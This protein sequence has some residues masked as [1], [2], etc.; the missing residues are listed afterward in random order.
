VS[1]TPTLDLRPASP[2]PTITLRPYQEEAVAAVLAKED[3]G[4]KRQVVA[5]PTGCGKTTVFT[6]LA[7]RLDRETILLVHRDELVRQAVERFQLVWPDASVG[8][9]KAERN[10]VG[11]QVV[12]ASIQTLARERRRKMLVP[13][14]EFVIV[15]ECHHAP[16]NTY[17]AVLEHLRC[18]EDDGPLLLGV[19]ATPDR[20][21][22]R[23]LIEI[24]Q[25][26]THRYSLRTAMMEGYLCDLKAV[27]VL[28]Q[29]DLDNVKTSRGDYQ[30]GALSDAMIEADAP[31]HIV[32]AWHEHASDRKTLVFVPTVA[33][34]EA[35]SNQFQATGANADWVCGATPL[36]ERR[37]L[38]NRFTEGKTQIVV[39]VGVLTEGYDEPSVDC[40]LV[41]RP[42]KSR[43]LC[44]QLV[45]R[46][47]R[48]F[49][50]KENCLILDVV[51][52]ARRHS[53]ANMAGLL[54]VD[55]RDIKKGK[56][57]LE[58]IAAD[59]SRKEKQAAARGKLVHAEVDLWREMQ[60]AQF[61]WVQTPKGFALS[62]ADALLTLEKVGDGW[63][64]LVNRKD[65]PR[66]ILSATRQGVAVEMAQGMAEDYARKN[67][68]QHLVSKNA[69][70][71]ERPPS[72][73]Q[74]AAA[75]KMKIPV[76]PEMS[77]GTL[78]DLMTEKIATFKQQ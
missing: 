54:G 17:R 60:K 34:A 7:R 9:V 26:I 74:L 15:D 78:S 24:F 57:G 21:D 23:G 36:D 1:T 65:K 16:A 20:G 68:S 75:A 76:T 56:S 42:T 71:R 77:A 3:E 22:G 64:V 14:F 53:L 33:M 66:T 27:E 51:G 52:I 6:E 2:A 31:E 35:V 28:L 12:V 55:P 61:S 18:F 25:E 4:V 49:P 5:H 30:D 59:I 44:Q 50:G 40:I 73:K 67:G 70:W 41:A 46:G 19:T 10:E 8:V 11:N 29:L 13:R 47:C 72:P 45:G 58:A 37:A 48:K 63:G 62:I 43:P 38:L 69:A 32:E 39:N